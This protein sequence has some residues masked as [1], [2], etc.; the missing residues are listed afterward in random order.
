MVLSRRRR[1]L[2]I[3]SARGV[4]TA[5]D[6]APGDARGQRSKNTFKLGE[7]RQTR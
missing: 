4:A 2:L 7:K 6:A 5:K 1:S 3:E